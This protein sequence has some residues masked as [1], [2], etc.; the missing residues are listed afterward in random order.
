MS[1][2][3]LNQDSSANTELGN[4]RSENESTSHIDYFEKF[5]LLDEAVPG[6][7]APELQ[8]E[9]E[10]PAVK[11]E[12]DEQKP[13]KSTA[14]ES[15]SASEESFVFVTDVDIVGE[16]LDEVF[17]GEGAPADVMQQRENDEEEARLRMRRESQRSMKGNGSVLFESEE[18][19]LTP[20]YISSG[21]PKIIDP[22]LLEEP[23]A[24]SFMYSDLYEDA[25]GERRKSD[26]EFSEAESVASEK[27]YKRRLSE[28]EEADGYL[29]KFILKDE[30]PIVE[31]QSESAEDKKDGR[32]MWSQN[33]FE[34][35]GCLT[36][37]V[38]EDEKKTE[39]PKAECVSVED[40][41]DE[42]KSALFQQK[43]HSES[44]IESEEMQ[45]F[46]V[47]QAVKK[48][49]VQE[50]ELRGDQM[51]Q[52]VKRDQ[53]DPLQSSVDE[54]LCE[55][56]KRE[57]RWEHQRQ[58]EGN[59]KAAQPCQ[60][61][62]VMKITEEGL[63]SLTVPKAKSE[64]S[65]FVKS[66]TQTET[67]KEEAADTKMVAAGEK[68]TTATKPGVTVEVKEPETLGQEMLTEPSGETLQF[69]DKKEV[70]PENVAPVEVLTD[71][72]SA[73]CAVVEV[74]DKVV[75][76]KDIQT[77]VQID[78]KERA[79]AATTDVYRGEK[80]DEDLGV[81]TTGDG[82]L[83]EPT[84]GIDQE[85]EA[86]TEI[87]SV[88]P[89][90]E[91]D[92]TKKPHE[93][94]ESQRHQQEESV[95]VCES[96]KPTAKSEVRAKTPTE[97]TGM[98]A[99]EMVSVGDEFILLVP[100]GQAVEMDVN[101][102]QWSDRTSVVVALPEPGATLAHSQTQLLPLVDETKTETLLEIEP[103]EVL[104]KEIDALPVSDTDEQKVE[105][106]VE[107]D[108]C[109]FSNLSRFTPQEDVPG[110]QR[111]DIQPEEADT[112]QKLEMHKVEY[113]PESEIVKEHVGPD[114]NLHREDVGQK[115]ELEEEEEVAE[116]PGVPADDLEYEVISNH[117]AKEMLESKIH[118]DT[119][120]S[121]QDREE[122]T[123]V[124]ME[125][126]E[127]RFDLSPEEELIEA[128]YE[129]IDAEEESQARLAA[130]LQGMDWFCLTCGCLLMDDKCVSAELHSHEVKAVDK[131]YEEIKVVCECFVHFNRELT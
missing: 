129:I 120:E 118:R 87:L 3:D 93:T 21:P 32:M 94:S 55:A 107:E 17:Y 75:S 56:E 36:R 9:T 110:L 101:I 115:M 105:R 82:E 34:M 8:E 37:A 2:Q 100:K 23:T 106:D 25:V 73:V 126:K 80:A 127:E 77:Q 90:A 29:E 7:Q 98:A 76:D 83:T 11:P 61:Q 131:A 48:A 92:S 30:T 16:H 116:A 58:E 113:V 50:S 28:S 66:K 71:C 10:T 60:T 122:R 128:D 54:P 65:V 51:E 35:T 45:Y 27:S 41:S 102:G 38:E 119:E 13:A 86:E 81:E 130:E 109:M 68:V 31:V 117:D 1:A 62:K 95:T 85:P 123:E 44:E 114:I 89:E 42:L 84:A 67:T 5:T 22:I 43:R 53:T 14:R 108:E 18:T 46:L 125:V 20:I 96:D 121:C 33:E 49:S 6:E 12:A 69:E 88:I 97:D 40:R 74:T 57:E 4:M 26:E 72:D 99:Q 64:E 59:I 104:R 52:E 124:E 24:M 78:L 91:T 63:E 112:E 79:M 39:K 19:I 103:E 47:N 111:G 70:V 15:P